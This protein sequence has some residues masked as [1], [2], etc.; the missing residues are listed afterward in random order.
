MYL[1]LYIYIFLVNA[2][3]E[4]IPCFVNQW[5]EPRTLLTQHN[6]D[7]ATVMRGV[8]KITYLYGLVLWHHKLTL[9]FFYVT[10]TK[11]HEN[12]R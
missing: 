6:F 4:D 3:V 7:L 9:L 11:Q 8:D 2:E 10:K 12:R 5:P 1:Y